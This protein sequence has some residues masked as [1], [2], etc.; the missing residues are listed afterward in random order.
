[1]RRVLLLLAALTAL[2]S[3]PAV[4]QAPARC[5]GK[6]VNPVTDICWSCLFPLSVGGVK[7]WPSDRPDTPNP[8][9]PLCACG[10]PVPRIGIAVGFWEP[11]RLVDVT[12]K[13]W[14]FPNLGGLKLDPSFDIG[15]GQ[16]TG[17]LMGGGRTAGTANWHVHWYVYPLLH[18]LEI[19]T[20]FACFEQTTFDMAYVTEV[21]PTW[22][23]DVLTTLINP[24]VALFANPTA[25][26]ACAGD[27]AAATANL[28]IDELFWCAGCQGSLYPMNGNVA[29]HIARVQSSRL[30]AER[31]LYKMHRM[32]LAW[33]TAGSKA[34][35]GKYLMPVLK[36]SQY[37]I[38][39]TNP[40]PTVSGR[41]A[42]STIGASSLP[43][44][45]GRHYPVGGEDMGYL[46]W[47]K[48]NCC[49]L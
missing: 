23:D 39:M 30:A 48:R 45:S 22:N 27:C 2:L 5:T 29:A 15:M 25:K 3:A 16:A 4:A 44:D 43:P 31:M 28:P 13:P 6:F 17:P 47:R 9:S 37:R 35:C 34:L 18:W 19:L 40:T 14:C 41:Y 21:D 46:V 8:A 7:I 32:G 20:D 49:M 1:V 12:A 36:K 33:G 38:Q 42:C 24:E 10:S 26:A 11:A